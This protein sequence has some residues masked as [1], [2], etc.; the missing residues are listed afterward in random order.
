MINS[1]SLV[2]TASSTRT[3]YRAICPACFAQQAVRGGRLADHG[4]RRPQQWHSNVGTCAGAGRQHFGTVEGRDYTASLAT[5]L[6][7]QA[8]TADQT[9]RLVEQGTSPVYGRKRVAVGVSQEVEIENPLP[10]QRTDY[11]TK[12]RGAAKM[13]RVQASEFDALVAKWVAVEPITVT[14][15]KATTLLHFYSARIGGKVC[16][17]SR[18]GAMKGMTTSDVARV[19]CDK[20]KARLARLANR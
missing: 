6:R 2:A 16:A 9:A 14:V 1:D 13:M 4:Y 19:T 5:S 8:S 17:S 3:Q 7:L 11:A 20:C 10:W 12:L 18:M 15:Q